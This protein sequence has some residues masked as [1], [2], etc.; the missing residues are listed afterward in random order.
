MRSCGLAVVRSCGLAVVR[1]CG[2]AVVRSCGLVVVRSCGL[3]VLRSCGPAVVRS[4]GLAVLRSCSLAVVRSCSSAGNYR[5]LPTGTADWH[6][7]LPTGTALPCNLAARS[8]CPQGILFMLAP[9]LPEDLIQEIFIRLLR[10]GNDQSG[11]PFHL[12]CNSCY[13]AGVTRPASACDA[14]VDIP[15]QH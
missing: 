11:S 7:R 10:Y 6:C 8:K 12:P 14:V 4:C 13:G 5:L 1:S 2:L 3:A 9:L 15:E